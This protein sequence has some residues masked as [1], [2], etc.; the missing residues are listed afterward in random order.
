M[1]SSL[2]PPV[3]ALLAVPA[4]AEVFGAQHKQFEYLLRS[5]YEQ[6]AQIGVMN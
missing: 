3:D 4:W 5:G 6:M 2:I 1:I